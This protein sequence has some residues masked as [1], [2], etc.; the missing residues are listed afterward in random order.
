MDR[1]GFDF[2]IKRRERGGPSYVVV[3]CGNKATR[4]LLSSLSFIS[5]YNCRGA[6]VSL[7]CVRNE[8]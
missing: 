5:S 1:Y 4:L 8:L 2:W 7:K 3:V 6:T